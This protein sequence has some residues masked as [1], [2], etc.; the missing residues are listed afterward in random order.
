M[1]ETDLH[2]FIDS[3]VNYFEEI[4]GYKPITGIPY[5]KGA[6]PVVLEYTGIIGISGKRKGSIY[7]T[8]SGEMLQTL[9][10]I[11]LGTKEVGSPEIKDLIGEVANTISGNVRQAF[12]T[13]FMISV[14]VVVEGKAKDIKTP[15]D[16]QSFVIPLTWQD[17][18][19]FLIVCLE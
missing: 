15:D 16:I 3:T 8:A 1:K 11:I 13:D 2:F 6:E 9:A 4:T 10:G 17:H 14:P 19:S 18:K 5:L 12:G 7:I